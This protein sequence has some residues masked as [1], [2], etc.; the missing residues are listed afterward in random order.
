MRL[1]RINEFSLRGTDKNIDR[2]TNAVHKTNLVHNI[3]PIALQQPIAWDTSFF[4]TTSP[5]ELTLMPK[6][7]L[8]RI[9]IAD[10]LQEPKVSSGTSISLMRIMI[11]VDSAVPLAASSDDS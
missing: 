3:S 5:L 7:L 2:M 8:R 4:I 11:R 1:G 10:N 6:V 9:N